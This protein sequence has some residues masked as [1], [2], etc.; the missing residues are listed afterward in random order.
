MVRRL[1]FLSHADKDKKIAEEIAEKLDRLYDVFVAHR[2]IE[3]SSEWEL[4]LKKRIKKCDLFLI[5]LS[6]N[7]RKANYTDQE[8]GIAI[9]CKRK[10]FPISIDKTKPYGFM[11]KYQ[12]GNI[13]PDDMNDSIQRLSSFFFTYY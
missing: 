13:N 11:S 8:V 6:E 12:S 9:Q 10:I 1:V 7:F 5:L 4:E 3:I 2:D